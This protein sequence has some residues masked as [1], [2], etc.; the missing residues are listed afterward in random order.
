[1]IRIARLILLSFVLA[2][3]LAP[4]P[5]P[6][7]LAA[8]RVVRVV[9]GDTVV[10]R[11]GGSD[12]TCRLVGVDTPE[13]VA[14]GKPVQ[15]GGPEATAFLRAWIAGKVVRV[16]YDTTPP[17]RDRYGRLLVYL[18][19]DMGR[20]QINHELIARG[21]GRYDRRYPTIYRAAYDAA[22]RE[23]IRAGLGVWAPKAA[24]VR[25]ADPG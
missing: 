11:R 24:G 22:E 25:L 10:L 6:V 15:P 4:E 9:D 19:A 13:T 7:P 14:P 5:P 23:A 12:V 1:M 20:Q 17:K 21:Y 2:S 18:W 8:N 16:S 3:A